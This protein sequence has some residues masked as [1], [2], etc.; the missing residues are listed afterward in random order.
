MTIRNIVFHRELWVNRRWMRNVTP[1]ETKALTVDYK[2]RMVVADFE[3]SKV[4]IP[5]EN[6]SCIERVEA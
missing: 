1:A 4:E 5:L 6:V 2:S 3:D